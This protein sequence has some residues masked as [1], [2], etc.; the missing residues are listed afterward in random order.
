MSHPSWGA[1]IE[2]I[3]NALKLAS[4]WLVAPLMGCVDC[5]WG[6]WIEIFIAADLQAAFHCRTP[7][8]V[9]GL[10]YVCPS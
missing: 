6:A 3:K 10:K 9:R 7:H 4:E 8:G 1:W 5:S 2:I